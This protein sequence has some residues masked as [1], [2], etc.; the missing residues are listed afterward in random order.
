VET[1]WQHMATFCGARLGRHFG[2]VP[3]DDGEESRAGRRVFTLRWPADQS[4]LRM[5]ERPVSATD[6]SEVVGRDVADL[7]ARGDQLEGDR[8]S[9]VPR[10]ILE[11]RIV[12]LALAGRTDDGGR[13]EP[14]LLER[15]PFPSPEPVFRRQLAILAARSADDPEVDWAIERVVAELYELPL[16]QLVDIQTRLRAGG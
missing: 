13:P 5:R 6:G 16:E 8:Q 1:L 12:G 15:L 9:A 11:S 10:A 4:R 2:V 3:A 14:A 7:I